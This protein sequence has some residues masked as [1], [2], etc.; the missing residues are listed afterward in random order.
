[1]STADYPQAPP[2]YEADRPPAGSSKGY[3]AADP[4]LASA[5]PSGPSNSWADMPEDEIEDFKVCAILLS[6]SLGPLL[7]PGRHS[8]TAAQLPRARS[9]FAR[10]LSERSTASSSL[11]YALL[12][13]LAHHFEWQM[14]RHILP[15]TAGFSGSLSLARSHPCLPFFTSASPI[16]PT[17]LS[18]VS[19]PSSSPFQWDPLS[20]FTIPRLC[21]RHSSSRPSCFL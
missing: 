15:R 6:C 3:G 5:V 11:R 12:Q 2:V 10:P 9:K 18:L 21:S 16:L 19:S 4:L 8:S 7:S 14:L 1:M 17:S 13:S 20:H